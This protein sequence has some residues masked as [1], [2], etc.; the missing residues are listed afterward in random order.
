MGNGV[1]VG[2]MKY[3]IKQQIAGIFIAVMVGTIILVWFA[4]STFLEKYYISNKVH[5]IYSAYESLDSA[6]SGGSISSDEF[7]LELRRVCD[8][9]NISVV[10]ID[11]QS[12]TI[13]STSRDTDL[14]IRR[15]YDNVF[16]R[17][18][19][20]EKIEDTDR[21]SLAV[22]TDQGMGTDY[23]EMWGVLDN[24]NLFLI[25]SPLESIRDSAKIA[26]K[27]LA[28]I[29]IVVTLVSAL[30]IWFVTTRI[31]KPI[32]ELKDISARMTNLDFEMHYKSRGKNEID[33]LGEHMNQ[34]SDTLEK[35]ISELKTANNELQRDIEKKEEIDE[36]RKEF[37]A[38]VSHELKTPIA[39][40][41]GYAEGLKEGIHDDDESKDF[42]CDVI[43]DESGKMNNMVK[44][45]LTLNQLEFGNDVI[46]MERFDVVAMIHNFLQ[47][48]EILTQ[49][50]EVNVRMEQTEPIYVWADEFKTEEVIRNYFS[51][52]MNH[53]KGDKIIDIKYTML[54]NKVRIG[55]FNTGDPIP[56]DSLP[57]LW[58]KFYKVDKARTREYGGSGVG[59]SIVKAI[60]DSMNQQYGV[61]NYTNGVEFWIELETK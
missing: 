1:Q 48:A 23:L 16:Q 7:D 58:E 49:Q 46:T 52:A 17:D 18:N 29:G 42:Y 12:N 45:L 47:S 27:F 34:L 21:Y 39:L 59:L 56:E 24:G 50:N 41:Q 40:I 44:K 3:S 33:L 61:I 6:V 2:S 26:N 32:M 19:K 57:H 8:I 25:R 43:I 38:N 13:K 36:I 4:N 31:T 51:N 37:L 9:Y 20:L 14:L 11:A 22:T 15:L 35:T 53:V 55:I 10:V 5:A 60:M 54:E 28:Y 30:L